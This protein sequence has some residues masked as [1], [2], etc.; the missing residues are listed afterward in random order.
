MQFVICC[1]VTPWDDSTVPQG[2]S[3]PS[4]DNITMGK[5]LLGVTIHPNSK[6]AVMNI[7]PENVEQV[8][9]TGALT[10]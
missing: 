2:I 6:G 4:T 8:A 9:T 7:T 5:S 3:F 10:A 1:F